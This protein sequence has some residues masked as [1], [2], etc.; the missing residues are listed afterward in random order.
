MTASVDALKP[1]VAGAVDRLADELEA[2]SHRI[3]DTPE[4]AF[5][6]EKAHAWLTEFLARHGARVERGVGGL[7]TAFRATIEGAS[8]G[9]TIAIMAEYDALPGIGHACG[10]N[11]IATAGTGAGAALA[12]GLGTLPF[13]GRVVV[14]GTPAEEGGAGKVKLMEAGVFKDVDAAMMI[15]G[16]CGT[17]VW[18][19]SL[20]IVKATAEF[21]G[22]ATHASSWPWRGVNALNAVIQL[23]VGLDQMRQQLRPDA[24]VH[25]IIVK[26][27][28]QPNIIPEYTRADFYLR[29]LSKDYCAELLRRFRG[30]AEGAAAATGC[31]VEITVDP[32]VHDPLR[33]NPTMAGLFEKNLALIDFPVD[34][35]DGEA[36]YG[37]TDCGNVSQALPTIHPYIRISPDGVPGHSRE[38][39]E[40]A[41][42]PLAR[43][44]IVAGAKALALTALDLLA[45]PEKLAA[46]KQ[47][48]ARTS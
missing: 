36:G 32:I 20:G 4:L 43:A 46:A 39:A 8:P 15:H 6:E 9:P 13:P 24:R 31:R 35:D 2:L 21:H 30:C 45:S 44:G 22:K 7:P 38:F 1:K 16:R 34:P 18:R 25:G 42:S 41:R 27:G 47:D 23:F 29:A 10:H 28:E 12:A 33:P 14:I 17:Q 48:F 5:K 19:P 3:H 40:W 37:S 11:A 26:G